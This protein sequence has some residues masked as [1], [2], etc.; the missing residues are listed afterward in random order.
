MAMMMMMVTT[1]TM[2]MMI[3][4]VVTYVP[5]VAVS[6]LLLIRSS[7]SQSAVHYVGSNAGVGGNAGEEDIVCDFAHHAVNVCRIEW[8][9]S[10]SNDADE[11]VAICA[12]GGVQQKCEGTQTED[13]SVI[14][15]RRLMMVK[16]VC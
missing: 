10:R 4:A 11:I 1:I 16:E 2:T 5:C 14:L 8:M 15:G 13:T 3:M 6:A 7:M 12:V 9:V